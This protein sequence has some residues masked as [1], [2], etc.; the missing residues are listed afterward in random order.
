MSIYKSILLKIGAILVVCL[1]LVA[2]INL[3]LTYSNIYSQIEKDSISKLNQVRLQLEYK[4]DEINQCTKA[5]VSDPIV[6]KYIFSK[7]QVSDR[8]V[9][10]KLKDY[11]VQRDYIHSIALIS[12]YGKALWEET[13][14]EPEYFSVYLKENWYR[15]IENN[16]SPVFSIEHRIMTRTGFYISDVNSYIMQFYNMEGNVNDKGT[17]V[18][19]V[20]AEHFNNTL[21]T[22][23]SDFDELAMVNNQ[24]QI[25]NYVL[26]D[27]SSQFDSGTLLK[28]EGLQKT[29]KNAI[30]VLNLEKNNG[31]IIARYPIEK[32]VQNVTFENSQFLLITILILLLCGIGV[33]IPAIMRIVKPLKELLN[34]MELVTN[35]NFTHK[36][37]TELSIE[38]E[39]QTSENEIILLENQ[40]NIMVRELN[41]KMNQIK[42]STQKMKELEI[43]VLVSQINPHFLYNTLDTIIYLSQK[44][45]A[46]DI[47]KITRNLISILQNTIHIVNDNLLFTTLEDEVKMVKCYA[48]I[49]EY[50]YKNIFKIEWNIP[51]ELLDI[52]IPRLVL[53]PLV[54]NA[55]F[56]GIQPKGEPGTI[57]I[58]AFLEKE[59][60]IIAV[61]DDGVGM[62]EEQLNKLQEYKKP[63]E[64]IH[65][66]GYHSIGIRNIYERLKAIY[67]TGA[68]LYFESSVSVGTLATLILPCQVCNN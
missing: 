27:K 4:I 6:Q 34:K 1:L 42:E 47:E 67:G 45:T 52:K 39:M 23:G 36:E 64:K 41:N 35:S 50:R 9:I 37:V 51:E 49:Q 40:F 25:T 56:H 48:G 32:V 60:L 53:Q 22:M 21:D 44:Y 68:E 7:N 13:E 31:K 58:S 65:P 24:G 33:M 46:E 14:T 16:I 30:I 54:E 43:G 55:L 66:E 10:A 61:K 12:S 5:I 11:K 57:S 62:N 20:K 28:E 26:R 59:H 19:N 63:A 2:L 17:I 3:I 15:K 18:V 38:T 8:E 29:G